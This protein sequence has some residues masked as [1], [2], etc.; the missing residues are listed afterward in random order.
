[1]NKKFRQATGQA[2]AASGGSPT[3]DAS[4]APQRHATPARQAISDRVSITLSA[5][6]DLVAF[7]LNSPPI[8]I[9]LTLTGVRLL[10]NLLIVKQQHSNSTIGTN[11][12]PIQQMVDAFLKNR[13]LEKE[14]EI[15][16]Q[17]ETLKEMF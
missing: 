7:N 15:E 16:R 4:G 3:A 10:R 1:M 17:F 2:R 12:K 9:P 5:A 6:G 13:L 14:I 8:T 11:A